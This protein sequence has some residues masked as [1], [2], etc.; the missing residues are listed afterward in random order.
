MSFE[1]FVAVF[2][3]VIGTGGVAGLIGAYIAL[4]KLP[5]EKRRA[6]V[7]I[8]AIFLEVNA[9]VQQSYGE[10]ID[11]L[12]EHID[13][14][15]ERLDKQRAEFTLEFSSQQTIIEDLKIRLGDTIRELEVTKKRLKEAEERADRLA[16][17]LECTEQEYAKLEA[18]NKRLRGGAAA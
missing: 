5:T 3:A 4:R 10:I 13:E 9:K 6:E 1:Q 12:R 18:E 14:M 17:R 2:L 11:E 16:E 8:Q 15:A 7:D